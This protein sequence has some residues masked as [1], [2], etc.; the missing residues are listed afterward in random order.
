ME[1]SAIADSCNGNVSKSA[2]PSL[3]GL[4]SP[5]LEGSEKWRSQHDGLTDQVRVCPPARRG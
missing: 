2:I 4:V 3:W 5:A 1:F